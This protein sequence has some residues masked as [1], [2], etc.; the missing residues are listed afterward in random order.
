MSKEYIQKHA[1]GYRINGTRVSLDS[2]VCAFLGGLSPESIA[3]D[4]PVLTL[5]EVYG[6]IAWYLSHREEVDAHLRQVNDQ[7]ESL[8]Q[9]VRVSY[10]LL[11]RKLDAN[12]QLLDAQ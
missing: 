1:T 4:F 6:A 10:P 7:F 11:N 2:I 12:R 9:R 8:Q 3:E 5:E